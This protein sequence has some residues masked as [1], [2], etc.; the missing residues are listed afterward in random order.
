LSAGILLA[1]G[2]SLRLLLELGITTIW[3]RI[4]LLTDELCRRLESAGWRVFSSR[5]PS[6]KSGIVSVIPRRRE[7]RELVRQARHQGI[8]INHRAG[9]LRISPH[10]YNNEEELDRLM[11][12]LERADV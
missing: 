11:E 6:E 2:A 8:V 9:R 7:A 12:F 4:E 1:F 10:C 3:Q 5:A